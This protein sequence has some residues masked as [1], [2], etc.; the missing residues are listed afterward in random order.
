[1][2]IKCGYFLFS[3]FYLTVK[4]IDENIFMFSFLVC[5][6]TFLLCGQI[7]N[8]FMKVYYYNFPDVIEK[9][10]DVCIFI[11]LVGLCIGYFG[12]TREKN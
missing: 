7:L 4:N 10:V 11:S 1:M 5:F 3:F 9:H 6:F 8:R 12:V 2:S